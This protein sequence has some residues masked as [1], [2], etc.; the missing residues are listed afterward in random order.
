MF[1]LVLSW[2]IL[3]GNKGGY[4]NHC[5]YGAPMCLELVARSVTESYLVTQYTFLDLIM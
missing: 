3:T 2:P 4:N 1:K 5:K